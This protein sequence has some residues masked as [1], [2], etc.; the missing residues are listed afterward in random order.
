M[1]GDE[2]LNQDITM[3]GK[4]FHYNQA[5]EDHKLFA[6]GMNGDKDLNQDIT[7]KGK[8]FHYNQAPE[9]HALFA[10]GMNGDEDLGQDITMKGKG[11]HYSQQW[12]KK[13]LNVGWESLKLFKKLR[14]KTLKHFDI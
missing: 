6:T 1:N 8:E 11:F 13:Q 7:M 9:D 10:T 12:N 5:P 2:D 4:E 3:K 14:K